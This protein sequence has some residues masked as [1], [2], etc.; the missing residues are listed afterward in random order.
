MLVPI[1]N[2]IDVLPE[3]LPLLVMDPAWFRLAVVNE[4]AFVVDV[5]FLRI[6]LPV[7]DV[8]P[9]AINEPASLVKVVAVAFTAMAL[10]ILSAEVLLFC[11]IAVTFA[12]TAATPE[13]PLIRVRPVPVPLL[14]MV[15]L[16]LSVAVESVKA[17][18]VEVLFLSTRF[19]V[20]V[21]PPVTL[22]LPSVLVKV[23]AVALGLIAPLIRKSDPVLFWVMAVTFA[24]TGALI[25]TSLVP[26]P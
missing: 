23:N 18:L 1:T 13:L 11:V 17:S 14:V 9:L 25:V 10:V 15:P 8:P 5:L 6:K 4:T 16:W 3:P 19:P 21:V 22:K 26:E 7:P 12:P 24:P 20:P 2:S